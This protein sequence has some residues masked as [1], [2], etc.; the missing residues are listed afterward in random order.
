M[1]IRINGKDIVLEMSETDCGD[2]GDLCSENVVCRS[3]IYKGDEY[4]EPS[5]EM[6]V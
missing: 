1:T 3:W 6:L 4:S 5:K 2:C